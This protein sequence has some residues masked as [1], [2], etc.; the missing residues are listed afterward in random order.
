MLIVKKRD[1]MV[2]GDHRIYEELVPVDEAVG[3]VQLAA[4]FTPPN[5][6]FGDTFYSVDI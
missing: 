1:R 6:L 3:G 2:M 4:S 5:T